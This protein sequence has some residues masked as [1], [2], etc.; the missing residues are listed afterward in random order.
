MGFDVMFMSSGVDILRCCIVCGEAVNV[1]MIAYC[2]SAAWPV[3][4]SPSRFALFLS[5]RP[6][7]LHSSGVVLLS[8]TVLMLCFYDTKSSLPFAKL[9]KGD[10]NLGGII[11]VTDVDTGTY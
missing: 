11:L 7:I 5:S 6:S 2:L 4:L 10:S 1:A 3:V 9:K 8:M